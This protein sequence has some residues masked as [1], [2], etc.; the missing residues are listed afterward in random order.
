MN[1]NLSEMEDVFN[2]NVGIKRHN[3]DI[4]NIYS[5]PFNP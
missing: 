5:I 4:I 3:M 2:P 1:L